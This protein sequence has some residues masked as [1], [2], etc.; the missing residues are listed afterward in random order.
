MAPQSLNNLARIGFVTRD[1]LPG[2]IKASTMVRLL[3]I[4]PSLE[5]ADF[6]PTHIELKKKGRVTWW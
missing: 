2:E 3:E 6:V 1:T 5:I 4:F